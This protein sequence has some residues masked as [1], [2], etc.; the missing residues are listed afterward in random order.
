MK[1]K[2]L[3]YLLGGFFSVLL[4]LSFW[5]VH[6][7]CEEN[8]VKFNSD[9]EAWASCMTSCTTQQ[10]QQQQQP[11]QKECKNWCCGIKLNTDFP[12]IW[13]CIWT[14]NTSPTQVFPTMISALIKITMS[15]IFVAC[16]IIIIVAGVIWA[17][18]GED[19]GKVKTA[20]WLIKKVAIT[21]LLI[22][23]S[24]VILR[25]INPNFFS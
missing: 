6:A 24:W 15:L 20:Q 3:S 18:A 2:I 8:C 5:Y 21:I 12:I 1:N 13:N 16:L 9:E 11:T 10:Q 4:S 19:S 14:K 23:F 7:D 17:W 25:L 22:W